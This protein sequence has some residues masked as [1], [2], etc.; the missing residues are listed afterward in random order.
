MYKETRMDR[1]KVAKRA[2]TGVKSI[3]SKMLAIDSPSTKAGTHGVFTPA[4]GTRAVNNA[5]LSGAEAMSEPQGKNK[6]HESRNAQA[7]KYGSS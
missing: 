5:F 1:K 3:N 7:A 6:D 4:T 2:R